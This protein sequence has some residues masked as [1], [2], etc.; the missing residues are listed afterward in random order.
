MNLSSESEVKSFLKNYAPFSVLDRGLSLL[1]RNCVTE[2]AKSGSQIMASVEDTDESFSL[3]LDLHS[4]NNIKATCSCCT[5]EDLE[6]QWCHHL[7]AA[8]WQSWK[9]DFLTPTGGF[10]ETESEIRMNHKTPEEISAILKKT[11][12]LE[13]KEQLPEYYPEVNIELHFDEDRLGIQVFYDKQIQTAQAF[14]EA[15]NRSYR[16]LDNVLIQVLEDEGAWDE[17]NNIWYVNTSHS[18]EIILGLLQ[19]YKDVTDSKNNKKVEFSHDLLNSIVTAEWH[20]TAV[21]L[22]MY[23]VLNDKK[24]IKNHDIIGTGPFWTVLDNKVYKLSPSSAYLASI[25]PYSSTVTLSRQQAGPILEVLAKNLISDDILNIVNPEA[26]PETTIKTPKPSFA[27]TQKESNYADERGMNDSVKIIG[28]LDFKYPTAPKNKNVVYLPDREKEQEYIDHLN[29]IGFKYNESQDNYST[30]GDH[31]LDLIN[32]GDSLFNKSWKV[33]GIEEIK[34]KTKFSSLKINLELNTNK[35]KD[36]NST[37]DW[38]DCNISLLQNNANVPISMIFKNLNNPNDNWIKLDNG[39]WAKIPGGGIKQLKTTLGMITSNYDHSNTIKAKLNVAQAMSLNNLNDSLINIKADKKIKELSDKIQN[40]TEIK[41]VNPSALFK[42]KL[43]T[44]QKE[45]LSWLTFLNEFNLDGILADEMGLGKTIQTLA[46]LQTLKTSK[47]K[48]KKLTK[49]A[50]IVAPTSVT[51]NWLYEARKFTPN[52]KTLLLY[53]P[54][55]KSHFDDISNYDIVITSY[56]LLRVDKIELERHEYSYIILDEAQN[57]KNPLTSTAKSAKALKAEHRLALSGTP[58]ENRPL[59]LWSLFDFL[60]PGY[61]GSHKFFLK[62]IEKPILED[63]AKINATKTLNSKTKPFILRRLKADVEKQLPPKIESEMH[64]AM[65]DSQ[66]QLYAR[67]LEEVR[68][69]VMDAVDRKGVRGATISIL[70]ALLRL[71]QVCNHPNSIDGLKEVPGYDSGKFDLLKELIV[72]SI[73]SGK[74]ILLFSQFREMLAII[75]RWIEEEEIP[76]L[77]LDGA[78]KD[79]QDLVDRFNNDEEVRM[80]LISLKAGGTGLN[81]T[82]ADTVIIYDPWWN[83][84]VESQAIDRAHRIGQSKNVNVYRLVT[85]DS[86]EQKIMQLKEKKTGII[87]A[88]IN[89]NGLSNL[90][91]TKT[92]LNSLF[93]PLKK[94]E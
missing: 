27:I 35:D 28:I 10:L 75:R 81:L 69:K 85:E 26:Q 15:R 54:K 9:L 80:F 90:S 51:T 57:I 38:F 2:C 18:I 33:S 36:S 16:E 60:M 63:G 49:P 94:E 19:E 67:I 20:E 56:A 66:A 76:Y 53:G 78:T 22:I 91:L 32:E 68:P 52:L 41:P 23:W 93:S 44:Y 40:F 31:A 12:E 21:E 45:G 46:L 59:E 47:D 25:F 64:V 4:G 24:I 11:A 79:R 7:V 84:A 37:I 88:L 61:L 77:Y 83:P 71:R 39:A 92:D 43:R 72:E 34:S 70:S 3:T 50:L 55:R 58:T 89:D 13:Y 74:K 14:E 8:V 17:D 65:T 30:S 42:G 73:A 29:S 82:A 1:S 86:I 87:D 5:E 62:H 48:K 6:E